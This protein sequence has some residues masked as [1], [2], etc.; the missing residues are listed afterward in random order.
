MGRGITVAK[1]M[2]AGAKAVAGAAADPAADAPAERMA[3]SGAAWV[4]DPVLGT[5]PVVGGSAGWS[6]RRPAPVPAAAR[7]LLAD[8][9]RG[10][11]RAIRAGTAADRYAAAHLAA[12]RAAAAVLAAKARPRRGSCVNAWTLLARVAPELAEWAQFF[13]AGTARRQAA[14]AGLSGMVSARDA[15]DM[16]RQA[17]T[18]LDLVEVAISARQP[19]RVAG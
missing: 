12:L 17:A 16:V 3:P 11:G 5:R 18:F 14:Q 9:G 8:A 7:E 6:V 1:V 13:A 10:L 19:D 15:D 2:A 4:E